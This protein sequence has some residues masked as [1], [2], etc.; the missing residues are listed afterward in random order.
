MKNNLHPRLAALVSFLL[1]GWLSDSC[2]SSRSATS[3]R[4]LRF[5]YE[6]GKGYDYEMEMLFEQKILETP[7][8]IGMNTYYSIDVQADDGNV[9][10]LAA[11]YERF[12]MDMDMVGMKLNVDTEDPVDTAGFAGD[13]LA[14]LGRVFRAVKGKS[15]EMKVDGEGKVLE[16]KGFKEMTES[17]VSSLGL[18]PEKERETREK[19]K[20]QFGQQFNDQKV[21]EQFERFFYIFPAK[22]VKA[23]DS[24]KKSSHVS[25]LFS[26]NLNSTYTVTE[27]EGDMV[28]IGEKTRIV[29]DD[30]NGET[31][32]E[33]TGTLV[34]DS[35]SGLVV[36]ADL[37]LDM[38]VAGS[39]SIPVKIK[40]II[41]GKAR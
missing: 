20:Q 38:T 23:G 15:F 2:Q 41:R 4:M 9:K 17:I 22:E 27:M 32:G 12:K 13:K 37:Q 1:V 8:K 10:T 34:V 21:R 40:T 26:G 28:I 18:D 29:S 33:Q 36:K 30:E 25:G 3:S 31:L 24:W 14:M 5:N 16:V 6:N 7:V 39:L 11:R 35:R 19:M